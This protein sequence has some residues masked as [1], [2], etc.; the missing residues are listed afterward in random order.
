MT[1][2]RSHPPRSYRSSVCRTHPLLRPPCMT[3]TYGG[4]DSVAADLVAAVN[5]ASARPLFHWTS[6]SSCTYALEIVLS[7]LTIQIFIRMART[8]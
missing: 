4:G 3:L 8:T 5:R 7:H 2:S 6:A 1:L